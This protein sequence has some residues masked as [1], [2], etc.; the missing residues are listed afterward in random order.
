MEIETGR[1]NAIIGK[2]SCSCPKASSFNT[3]ILAAD[4][5]QLP[6]VKVTVFGNISGLYII[7]A[8][9]EFRTIVYEAPISRARLA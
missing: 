3:V 9:I 7:L 2:F 5:T 1:V 4:S 8:N 6:V